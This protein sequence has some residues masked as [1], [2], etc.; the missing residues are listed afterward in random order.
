MSDKEEF[1]PGQVILAGAGCGGI[2]LLTT[3]VVKLI[4]EADVIV[5]DDLI[6]KDILNLPTEARWMY[7]GKRR[8]K[9]SL[10][11]EEINDLL[12]DLAG[13]NQRVLRLK[14]G[15]PFVFGRGMEEMRA[16][17]QAGIAC[18]VVPGI[19]SAIAVPARF[20]I[21]LTDRQYASSFTVITAR[22][23]EGG[24]PFGDDTE[25]IARTPGTLVILMGLTR[26][27]EI[28]SDLIRAGKDPATPAAVISSP[29]IV[30]SHIVTGE[31]CDIMG[32]AAAMESP[33][34][35]VIGDVVRNARLP[36]DPAHTPTPAPFV[37]WTTGTRDLRERMQEDL[38]AG[39][40][41]IPAMEADGSRLAHLDPADLEAD[42]IV[43]T[44]RRGAGEFL[45][46]LQAQ[47]LDLRR[48]PKL[49]AVGKGTAQVLEEAGLYP[50][51]VPLQA[52]TESLSQALL[53][54]A[55]PGSRILLLRAK[56][57]DDAM[58]TRLKKRFDVRRKDLYEIRYSACDMSGQ[59]VPDLVVFASASSARAWTGKLPAP[60][61]CIS[62]ITASVL[63]SLHPEAEIRVAK[64]ISAPGLA[65]AIITGMEEPDLHSGSSS[66]RCDA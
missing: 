22:R 46:D 6:G 49:A 1:R 66:P 34:I 60:A 41:L 31:L 8:G 47:K 20:D 11:Q 50:D 2:R 28:V 29:D 24:R 42:W 16:L 39:V 40:E 44:S 13:Q 43:I 21:P 45:A 15:D 38:P 30:H 54:L 33:A 65:A 58:E 26:L 3:E 51:L 7:A 18:R 25:A 23:K 61:L 59:P 5:Y 53:D 55:E 62:E 37:V 48:V 32:K 10:V 9:H 57:A 17:R 63:Q 56:E 14:G 4:G 12:I 35:I 19:T 36:Q 52:T 27:P 64:D